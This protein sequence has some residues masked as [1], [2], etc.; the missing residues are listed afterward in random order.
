M[1]FFSVL[2]SK[3][4]SG[5]LSKGVEKIISNKE[6]P[7]NIKDVVNLFESNSKQARIKYSGKLFE[8]IGRMVEKQ[9]KF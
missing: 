1:H 9:S 5:E 3:Y 7:L 8:W 4:E 6:T 2:N